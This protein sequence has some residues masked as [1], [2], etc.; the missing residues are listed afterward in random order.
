MKKIFFLL[1][2]IVST[3]QAQDLLP[4]PKSIITTN[5]QFTISKNTLIRLSLPSPELK[6]YAQRFVQRLQNRSGVFLNT[7]QLQDTLSN[8][9]ILIQTETIVDTLKLGINEGYKIKVHQNKIT[10]TA[11]NN[12]GAYRGLETL[13]QLT[14]R[15][16]KTLY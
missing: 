1:A 16:G 4:Q 14:Q 3:A 15:N 9:E 7:T 13:L 2:I 6:S 12:I 11:D 10:I 5:G 8:H